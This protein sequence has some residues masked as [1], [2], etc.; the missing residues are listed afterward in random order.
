MNG[1]PA[2]EWATLSRKRAPFGLQVEWVRRPSHRVNTLIS[3]GDTDTDHFQGDS[4]AVK[5]RSSMAAMAQDWGGC[6][7]KEAQG[8]VVMDILRVLMLCERAAEL[9]RQRAH[10]KPEAPSPNPRISVPQPVRVPSFLYR[11]CNFS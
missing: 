7:S 4:V 8:V 10:E 6:D 5:K 2:V 1:Q 9:L 3:K 11:F